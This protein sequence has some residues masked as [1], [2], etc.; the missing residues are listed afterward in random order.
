MPSRCNQVGYKRSVTA[1][2]G[3]QPA[4]TSDL[5]E[6]RAGTRLSLS[7]NL[8]PVGWRVCFVVVA[9]F[10]GHGVA[11]CG[12]AMSHARVAFSTTATSSTLQ[13]I[14]RAIAEYVASICSAAA[15]AASYP[16]CLRF[17]AKT[18]DDRLGH[19]PRR[20][21]RTSV[22][23]MGHPAD[24]RSVAPGPPNVEGHGLHLSRSG[25]Q[26]RLRRCQLIFQFAR[27]PRRRRR[28][29]TVAIVLNKENRHR[30]QNR[31]ANRRVRG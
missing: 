31:H 26:S 18:G 9:G 6:Q 22:V 13:P 21:R 7:L 20:Q 4:K 11:G 2:A 30:R 12:K 25:L 16:A 3:L 23:Q 29:T 17:P 27:H 5:P 24:A 14:S 10:L 19:L 1:I 8:L 28:R 15:S